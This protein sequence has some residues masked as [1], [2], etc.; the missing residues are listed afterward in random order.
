MPRK[1]SVWIMIEY[2]LKMHNNRWKTEWVDDPLPLNINYLLE[3]TVFRFHVSN[4]AE[5][6]RADFKAYRQMAPYFYNGSG[7]WRLRCW[8]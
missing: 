2:I 5:D 6:G 4:T 3:T 8:L 7:G 1:F